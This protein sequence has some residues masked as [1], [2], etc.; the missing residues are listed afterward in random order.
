MIKDYPARIK[1]LNA[2]TLAIGLGVPDISVGLFQELHETVSDYQT[3]IT[4]R[5]QMEESLKEAGLNN[6]I[7]ANPH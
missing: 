7:V 5:T 2:E 4:E 1:P 6:L 3:A